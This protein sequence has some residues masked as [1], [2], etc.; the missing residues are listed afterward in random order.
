MHILV[1]CRAMPPPNSAD[2]PRTPS[3]PT[4]DISIVVPSSII[5]RFETIESRGKYTSC[6]TSP[7]SK[8]SW[9]EDNLSMSSVG[10]EYDES[11][12]IPRV[13]GLIGKYGCYRD[14]T[15]VTTKH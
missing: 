10:R 15:I 1:Q 5:V 6:T 9:L 4:I 2:K 8:M 12:V 14:D 11:L 7:C 13:N 3:F